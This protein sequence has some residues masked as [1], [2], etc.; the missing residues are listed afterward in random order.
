MAKA[1]YD[2]MMGGATTLH[3]DYKFTPGSYSYPLDKGASN[4]I[5]SGSDGITES[6]IY[7]FKNGSEGNWGTIN[8]GVSNNGTKTLSD[9]IDQGVTTAQMK[10]EFPPNGKVDL[11]H[12]FDGNPGISAAIKDDLT[13]IIGKPVSVPIYDSSGGNGNNTWYN[14][15]AYASVR[16]VAVSLTGNPKYVIVQPASLNDP[17]A[18]PDTSGQNS[19]SQGGI[20]VVH[21]SR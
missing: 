17:T 19:W 10:S 20:P 11:P 2:A 1:N 13:S 18:I 16:I 8:F 21:L 6:V 4:G 15:V 7:P 9:Q 5:T 3:D 14:V 12:K